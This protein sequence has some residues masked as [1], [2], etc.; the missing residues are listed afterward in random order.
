MGAVVNPPELCPFQIHVKLPQST[1]TDQGNKRHQET[2]L[3]R[4]A[5]QEEKREREL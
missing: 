1:G 5:R 4:K 3:G 2:R